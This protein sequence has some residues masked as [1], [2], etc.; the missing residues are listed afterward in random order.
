VTWRPSW[1][2]G[3]G[4]IAA[5]SLV[6]GGAALVATQPW[7]PRTERDAFLRGAAKKLGVTPA[8]LRSALREAM[9][10]RVDAAVAAGRLIKEEGAR[11]KQR[12]RSGEAPFLFPFLVP[13][14]HGRFDHGFGPHVH[15]GFGGRFFDLDAAAAY[16]G[17]SEQALRARLESGRTLAQ[18]AK[19]R[20]RSVDGLVQAL[21]KDARAHLDEAVKDGRLTA[22]ERAAIL[23]RVERWIRALVAR[24][25]FRP[26]WPD[27]DGS[28]LRIAPRAPGGGAGAAIAAAAWLP[29]SAAAAISAP[30]MRCPKGV[31]TGAGC[32]VSHRTV[33]LRV[34]GGTTVRARLTSEKRREAAVLG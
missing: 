23:Q 4:A 30:P 24:Q 33:D 1:K 2:A 34:S 29:T 8:K 10:D 9:L 13:P 14:G 32:G 19:A 22:K 20:G 21:V 18:I 16:L 15:G 7:S 11:L 26:V 28:Q 17:L 27:G 31:R 6:G 3:V 12:V 25:P 5:L